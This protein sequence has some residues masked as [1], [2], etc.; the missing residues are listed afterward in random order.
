MHG[1]TIKAAALADAAPQTFI[2]SSSITHT[3][4]TERRDIAFSTIHSLKELRNLLSSNK[5]ES[6]EDL[7]PQI[8][9][10]LNLLIEEEE[11]V[12]CFANSA[13]ERNTN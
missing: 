1:K 6:I 7:K 10:H 12:A 9:E 3:D 2:N 4:L 8:A 13:S 11:I 5:F